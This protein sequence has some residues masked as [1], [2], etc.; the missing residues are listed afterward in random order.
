MA[1]VTIFKRPV[2]NAGGRRTEG[3]EKFEW[4]VHPRPHCPQ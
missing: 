4:V 2:A 1:P 3:V